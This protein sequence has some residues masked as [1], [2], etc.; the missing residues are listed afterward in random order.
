VPLLRE[1]FAA[2]GEG[3]DYRY[4]VVEESE[5]LLRINVQSCDYA[6]YMEKLGA[7]DLGPLLVCDNDFSNAEGMGVKLSRDKTCMKGDGVC[8]FCFEIKR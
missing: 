5:D 7:R 1:D 4:E 6:R 3:I 8:N 2:A